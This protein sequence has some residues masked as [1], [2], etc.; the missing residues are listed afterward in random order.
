MS[1]KSLALAT[2]VLSLALDN[3]SVT[4]ILVRINNL[5]LVRAP[6]VVDGL[7]FCRF[8][9]FFLTFCQLPSQLPKGT[10]SKFAT[11]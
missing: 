10:Q 2:R 11:S 6:G 9:L 8:S 4:T 3:V 1:F 7:I 5:V